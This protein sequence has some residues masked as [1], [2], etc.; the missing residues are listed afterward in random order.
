M[1]YTWLGEL[2]YCSCLP[3]LPVPALVLLSFLLHSF[4]LGSVNPPRKPPKWGWTARLGLVACDM[5]NLMDIMVGAVSELSD[6]PKSS[7]LGF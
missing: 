5:Q 1:V 7:N 6:G 3:V 4:I 2:G